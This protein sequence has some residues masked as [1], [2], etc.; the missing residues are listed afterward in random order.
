MH[1]FSVLICRNL[2]IDK[3]VYFPFFIATGGA[4]DAGAPPG[5]GTPQS[6]NTY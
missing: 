2:F 4:G 5:A 1:V 3:T 6:K